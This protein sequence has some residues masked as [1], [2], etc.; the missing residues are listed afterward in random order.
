M[1]LRSGLRRL[2][3]KNSYTSCRISMNGGY[4]LVGS[5]S[6]TRLRGRGQPYEL[7][8][9]QRFLLTGGSGLMA[10]YDPKP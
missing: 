2:S 8:R 7:S 4:R 1:S 9:L 10:L 5:E 3:V 6:D